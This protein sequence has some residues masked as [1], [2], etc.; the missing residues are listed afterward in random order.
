M[1]VDLLD[2]IDQ[3]GKNYGWYKSRYVLFSTEVYNLRYTDPDRNNKI[4]GKFEIR[5]RFKKIIRK[6]IESLI[7][8][9]N[10]DRTEFGY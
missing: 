3:S 5:T 8:D 10:D 1:M 6:Y 2:F 7:N 4:I 9:E